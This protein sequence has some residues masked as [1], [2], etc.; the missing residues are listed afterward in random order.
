MIFIFLINTLVIINIH[1]LHSAL[2]GALFL[3]LYLIVNGYFVGRV[4]GKLFFIQESIGK[5]FHI[6]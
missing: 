6:L 2:F 1:F 4:T 5:V 3:V